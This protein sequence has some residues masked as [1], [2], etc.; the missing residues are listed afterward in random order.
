MRDEQPNGVVR[1]RFWQRGG[2]YDRNLNR[3]NTIHAT[4]AYIHENPVRRGLVDRAEALR[5]SGAGHYLGGRDVSLIPDAHS[6]P[7]LDPVKR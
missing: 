7:P 1:H 5:W 6:I 2:G 4:I 3:A